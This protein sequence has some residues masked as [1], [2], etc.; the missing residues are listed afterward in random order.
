MIISK[1]IFHITDFNFCLIGFTDIS[2]I[3]NEV[4]NFQRRCKGDTEPEFG[5]QCLGVNGERFV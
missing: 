1:K 5:K 3:S 2:E 4:S